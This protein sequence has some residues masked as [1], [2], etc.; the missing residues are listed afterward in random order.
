MKVLDINGVT[1]LWNKIKD[2]FVSKQGGGQIDVVIGEP[3][4]ITLRQSGEEPSQAIRMFSVGENDNDK[5]YIGNGSW[6]V[7]LDGEVFVDYD[8]YLGY[9]R[10]INID[11]GNVKFNNYDLNIDKLV[12][13]GYLVM[14]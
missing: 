3:F 7:Y 13:D 9:T 6:G 5:V 8:V 12:E 2:K 1:T 11:L 10:Q 14:K 4:S